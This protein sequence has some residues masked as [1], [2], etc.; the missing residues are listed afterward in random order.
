MHRFSD[1]SVRA[2]CL[3][4]RTLFIWMHQH[5]LPFAVLFTMNKDHNN[6]LT[7]NARYPQTLVKCY[8][9]MNQEMGERCYCWKITL[10]PLK[11]NNSS[12]FHGPVKDINCCNVTSRHHRLKQACS[13]RKTQFPRSHKA[14][15]R[16]CAFFSI[17]LY[18][19]CANN[20]VLQFL[21]WENWE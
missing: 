1:N 16:I 20:V 12:Q 4:L 14:L 3:I 19:A 8:Y 15:Y 6:L 17:L 9:Q 7:G 11:C 13:E 18:S 10:L 2:T 5:Q 21:T